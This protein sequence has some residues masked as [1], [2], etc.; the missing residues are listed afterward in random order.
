MMH[1][2]TS[3][4]LLFCS[5]VFLLGL[6]AP[7]SLADIPQVISYQGKVTDSGGTTVADGDHRF[8][9]YEKDP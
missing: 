5:T 9:W 2:Q 6:L 1:R 7:P 4:T 8:S 3:L